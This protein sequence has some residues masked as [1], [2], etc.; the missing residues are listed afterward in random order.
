MYGEHDVK[1]DKNGYHFTP[2]TI[3][4]SAKKG[5]P[6]AEKIGKA[7]FGL[8][9]HT[10]YHGSHLEHM[11]AGFDPDTHNFKEHP[12]VHL[13]NH[14]IN[15][16]RVGHTPENEAHFQHHLKAAQEE[17]R[18]AHHE[19][20]ANTH[21]HEEHLKTYINKTVLHNEKPTTEGF[22]KHIAEKYEK[23]I[24]KLK[25]DK[26]K[27]EK[28]TQ[29]ESHMRHISEHGKQYDSLFKMHHHIQ[30]A[31]NALVNSLS[32]APEFEHSIGKEKTG[33]EGFVITHHG[34]P[35]KLVNRQEFSRQNFLKSKNR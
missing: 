31:K 24:G 20:F 29:L 30:Q 4:Y 21:G 17:F 25:T 18:K 1:K 12:D 3:T 14:E 35:T 11:N 27:M 19:T 10:K 13:I 7:K 34:Q 28:R 26:K 23:E 15:T 9:V 6:E 22:K 16:A 8:V 33:P 5:S 2:N 32:P